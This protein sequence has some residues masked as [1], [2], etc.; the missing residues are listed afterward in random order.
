MCE[1]IKSKADYEN[2]HITLKHSVH[3]EQ[4]IYLHKFFLT[5]EC[6]RTYSTQKKLDTFHSMW[7]EV[8]EDY[9]SMHIPSGSYALTY[10]SEKLR[11]YG[12]TSSSTKCSSDSQCFNPY[13]Y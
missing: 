2:S 9:L 6:T 1:C 8:L 4:N 10:Y 12:N 13:I 3:M 5:V 7:S 11:P